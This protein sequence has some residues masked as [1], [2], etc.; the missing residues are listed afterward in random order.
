MARRRHPRAK[1]R[2]R[3]A[4]PINHSRTRLCSL[5]ATRRPWSIWNG[6][7]PMDTAAARHGAATDTS[8]SRWPACPTRSRQAAGRGRNREGRHGGDRGAAGQGATGYPASGRA[9]RP[10][11][12]P[13]TGRLE[14]LRA[15]PARCGQQARE[16][17][18]QPR[19]SV[20][21]LVHALERPACALI[22][23]AHPY[24]TRRQRIVISGATRARVSHHCAIRP[25][26]AVMRM[27]DAL[28][29]NLL[30]TR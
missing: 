14:V 15:W 5:R 28:A 25:V 19:R 6:C 1:R 4:L 30:E 2:H 23:T 24:D 26:V 13:P 9:T 3:P 18:E 10:A 21:P 22:G 17:T 12:G 8:E 11:G 20:R 16:R 7:S 29:P 27:A